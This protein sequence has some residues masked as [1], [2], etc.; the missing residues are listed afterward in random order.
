MRAIVI[1]AFLALCGL[2]SASVVTRLVDL[3]VDHFNP[4]DR[5]T[6]DARYFVNSEVYL[7]GGPLFIYVSG[8]FEVYDEFLT[9]GAVF[10]IAADLRGHVFALEHRYFGNSRPTADASTENLQ[11]LTVPQALADIAQ[12]IS[13]VRANYYGARNSRV[14]LWGRHYGGALAVWARQKYPNLVDGVWAS[15]APIDAPLEYPQ[16]M[17]NAFYTINS[18]GG[19]ECGNV[20]TGA[21]Q[22]IGNAI[23]ARDTSV[24]ERRLRLCSPI[25]ID[26][27]EDVARLFYGIAADIANNYVAHASYPEIDEKCTIMRA[28][29]DPSNP[30]ENDL[31][32]FARWYVDDFNRN[33]MCLNF[34]NT[35]V[36]ALYQQ[37]AWNTISTIAGRRQNFWLQCSQ[38][39]QF[40]IANEGERHPFG[41]RFD[42]SF[43]RTWC[44]QVFGEEL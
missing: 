34:N 17:P 31:D 32:G 3:R 44:A 24:V 41:W 5:R 30:P 26:I 10:E 16:L 43:F 14:I 20:I 21:M 42:L 25:D 19:P 1:F 40:P 28:L 22:M 27:P 11:F 38:L 15:S 23:R 39:G 37:T 7:P 13:F 4:F 35:A 12:F 9:Q 36:M 33:L 18:I 8:G 2:A 29:D 6:F